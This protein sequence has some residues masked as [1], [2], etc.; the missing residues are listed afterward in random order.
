MS[1]YQ[2][3]AREIYE[4]YTADISPADLLSEGREAIANR[5]MVERQMPEKAAYYAA[6]QILVYAEHREDDIP[7]GP[8]PN[9]DSGEYR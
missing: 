6:D 8:G 4:A 3:D 5:L 2:M 9:I 1:V 7:L